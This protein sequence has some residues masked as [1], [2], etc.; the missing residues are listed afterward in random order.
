MGEK[1]CR[2]GERVLLL[3]KQK[4]DNVGTNS[5]DAMAWNVKAQLISLAVDLKFRGQGTTS[6][7]GLPAVLECM[8]KAAL[9]IEQL[10]AH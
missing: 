2:Q 9:E 4:R 1:S 6:A 8:F 5:S 3:E 7:S 10:K